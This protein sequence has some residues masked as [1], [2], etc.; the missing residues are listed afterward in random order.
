[1][2]LHLPQAEIDSA[3]HPRNSNKAW[4]SAKSSNDPISGTQQKT[5]DVAGAKKA[6]QTALKLSQDFDGSDEARK[7]LAGL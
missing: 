1:L 2:T 4:R 5:G 6:L 7:T 3:P